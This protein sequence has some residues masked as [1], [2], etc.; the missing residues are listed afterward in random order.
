MIV[1]LV[2]VG[3]EIRIKIIIDVVNLISIEAGRPVAP[4]R[5]LRRLAPRFVPT[6]ARP[7]DARRPSFTPVRAMPEVAPVDDARPGD[8]RGGAAPPRSAFLRTVVDGFQPPSSSSL[9]GAGSTLRASVIAASADGRDESAA[10]G[11]TWD[12]RSSS[13]AETPGEGCG[14]LAKPASPGAHPEGPSRSS[15]GVPI[16]WDA[17]EGRARGGAVNGG[18]VNGGAVNGG[19]VA[20]GVGAGPSAVRDGVS[21][22][23]PG[24]AGLQ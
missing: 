15:S 12:S 17:D 11:A 19:A 23:T 6:A 18:A 1:L 21:G 4:G 3:L 8:T 16:A 10:G 7:L 22:S 24:A 2:T 9:S 5:W 13:H 20:A 14:T